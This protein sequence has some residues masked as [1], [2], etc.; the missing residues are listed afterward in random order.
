MF[1]EISVKGDIWAIFRFGRCG[2]GTH[3]ALCIIPIKLHHKINE[4]VSPCPNNFPFRSTIWEYTIMFDSE[5]IISKNEA[6]CVPG[7]ELNQ[8]IAYQAIT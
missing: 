1:A 8:L 6:R 3:G 2:Y 5:I 7:D 4:I